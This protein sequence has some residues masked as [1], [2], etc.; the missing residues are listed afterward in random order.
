MRF[1]TLNNGVRMPQFG[2]G[3]YKVEAGESAYETVLAALKVGYRMFDTAKMY[4]NESDIGRAIRDSKIDRSEIFVTSKIYKLYHGD[5]SKIEKDILDSLEKINL[6]YIDLMLIHWPSPDPEINLKAW[7]VL[8]KFYE[9]GLIKAIGVSNFRI[10]HIDYLVK[11]AKIKPAMN[12]VE[13]HPL[14][15]QEPLLNHLKKLN[16]NMTSYGPFAKGRVFEAPT[17]E[18]LTEI[19]KKYDATISQIIIAWGLKRGIVM[20]P[21][22]VH[23][24]RLIENFNAL[25]IEL[26]DEDLIKINALNRGQNVYTDPDNNPFT[27]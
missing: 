19:A 26:S 15:S 20:I 1:I 7:Q 12:Q 13:C 16:I 27:E 10:H 11:Y 18:A 22:T 2:L 17:S 21:K 24:E 5:Q 25:N 8:E 4:H 3:T 23:E 6:G 9:K 14:L